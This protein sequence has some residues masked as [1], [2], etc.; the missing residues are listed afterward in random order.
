VSDAKIYREIAERDEKILPTVVLGKA[1]ASTASELA[2]EFAKHSLP[3]SMGL[4][5]ITPITA[6]FGVAVEMIVGKLFEQNEALHK[7]I[8]AKVDVMLAEPLKTARAQLADVM[9]VRSHDE[10]TLA[11][12]DRQLASIYDVLY[13]ALSYAEEKDWRSNLTIRGYLALVAALMKGGGEFAKVHMSTLRQA[14]GQVKEEC[15]RLAKEEAQ[16]IKDADEHHAKMERAASL[17]DLSAGFGRSSGDRLAGV[18]GALAWQA[19]S[20]A[21]ALKDMRE[22]IQDVPESIETFCKFMEPIM[23]DRQSVFRKS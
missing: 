7:A 20:K 11:Q 14:A 2:K 12:V 17:P 23:A 22:A 10:A 4:L 15:E 1:I 13:K 18:E 6:V 9:K 16:A 21:K 8:K 5:A 3:A 19:R